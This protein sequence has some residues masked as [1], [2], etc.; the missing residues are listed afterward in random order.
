LAS[1]TGTGRI[2]DHTPE[3]PLNPSST[4]V[5]TAQDELAQLLT[6]LREAD[7]PGRKRDEMEIWAVAID[8][9]RSARR[10]HVR[11]RRELLAVAADRLRLARVYRPPKRRLLHLPGRDMRAETLAALQ[12]WA[13]SIPGRLSCGSYARWRKEHGAASPTRNTVA[14]TFGSWHAAM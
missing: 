3:P 4:W 7:L 6:M 10:L 8:E 14:A 9:L 5:V 12:A 1:S 11:P 13:G 2:Y